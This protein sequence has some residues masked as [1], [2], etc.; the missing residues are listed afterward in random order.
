M[1]TYVELLQRLDFV[2]S[3]LRSFSE[4][5]L[6]V[7][8]D[9]AAKGLVLLTVAG[10]LVLAMKKASAAARQTVWLLALAALIALPI[11]SAALPSW[12]ILPGWVKI[13]IAEPAE[14]A[15]AGGTDSAA[16]L[17][18]ATP[19][20][21]LRGAEQA[22]AHAIVP[23]GD[24]TSS[25]PR[26]A[27]EPAQQAGRDTISPAVTTVKPSGP[28][29]TWRSW[30]IPS[31][32]AA[33]LAG[34]FVCLLPVILGRISLHRLARRS[35]R[36]D[37][38]LAASKR[39]GTAERSADGSPDVWAELLRRAAQ[40]VGL[41]RPITLLQSSD[42]TMPMVWGILRPKLL[43]PAEA[44]DWTLQR[45]WVVLL[46]ELAHAHRRDC[47]AKL[48]AHVACSLYWFNPLCWVAFKLMQREAEAACDDLV[49]MECGG[50]ALSLAKGGAAAFPA[51][52]RSQGG[53]DATALQ[54]IR[55]SDYA[56]HLLEIA[57]GLP[58]RSCAKPGPDNDSSVTSRPSGM[59]AA[60]LP[61]AC[62]GASSIA[63]ARRSKLEGRLLAILDPRRN[64]RALTR[65]GIIIAAAIVI[66]IAVPLACIKAAAPQRF[67]DATIELYV[68]LESGK[69]VPSS[70]P[71][72]VLKVTDKKQ[73][74]ELLAFFPE[75]DSKPWNQR[76]AGWI[77]GAVIELNKPDGNKVTIHVSE[78]DDLQVYSSSSGEGDKQVK[79][80]LRAFLLALQKQQSTQLPAAAHDKFVGV[81]IHQRQ[82]NPGEGEPTVYVMVLRADGKW[83]NVWVWGDPQH[84]NRVTIK[85]AGP[86]WRIHSLRAEMSVSRGLTP[87]GKFALEL[88]YDENNYIDVGEC[89]L[90]DA[91]TLVSYS[92]SS[93]LTRQD[94]N[95]ASPELARQLEIA[96]DTPVATQP[97]GQVNWG[98][99]VDG[100]KVS[101]SL[102]GKVFDAGKPI[103]IRWAIRNV[104]NEDKTIRWHELHYCPVLF[105]VTDA[106]GKVFPDRQDIR[107]FSNG[108]LPAP[109]QK[110][111]LRP[112]ETK[113]TTFDLSRFLGQLS[114]ELKI[115]GL[116][117]PQAAQKYVNDPIIPDVAMVRVASEPV[118]LTVYRSIAGGR[119]ELDKGIPFKAQVWH[120]PDPPH[121]KDPWMVAGAESLRFEQRDGLLVGRLK[122]GYASWPKDTYLAR[123]DLHDKDGKV[124]A[125]D[126]TSIQSSG[127]ILGTAKW[128]EETLQFDFGPLAQLGQISSFRISLSRVNEN[129]QSQPATQPREESDEK[130]LKDAAEKLADATGRQWMLQDKPQE[131][132]LTLS[133]EF[134]RS[135]PRRVFTAYMIYPMPW[136]VEA[137]ERWN[138]A[139]AATHYLPIAT[140]DQ[141]TLLLTGEEDKEVSDKIIRVLGIKRLKDA[142]EVLPALEPAS[143]PVTQPANKPA[144][145]IYLITGQPKDVLF[146]KV[147]LDD[148]TLAD[149]PLISQGDILEYDWESHTIRL[150]SQALADR[151][152]KRKGVGDTDT[153]VVVADGQRLYAGV[154]MS[155]ISSYLPHTPVIHVGYE[156]EEHQPAKAVR[157]FPSPWS[158]A[159][160]PRYDERLKEALQALHLLS[161]PDPASQ[162]TTQGQDEQL[163]QALVGQWLEQHN[164]RKLTF[165]PD[166]TWEET[167]WDL[168][169]NVSDPEWHKQLLWRGTWELDGRTLKRKV[170]QCPDNPA[171][172][173]EEI[174]HEIRSIKASSLE[175]RLPAL[176]GYG[177]LDDY[178]RITSMAD[179]APVTE[180]V[181]V[182]LEIDKAVVA[183][184]HVKAR[185]LVQTL[186]SLPAGVVATPPATQHM[187][188]KLDLRTVPNAVGSSRQ[189]ATQPV[190][191]EVAT[192]QAA[193]AALVLHIVSKAEWQKAAGVGVYR[194]E[195]LKSAG[196]VHCSTPQQIIRVANDNFRGTGGLVLLCIDP[197]RLKT[198]LKYENLDGGTS[199]FPHIYGPLNLDAVVEV[200]D[201]APQADGTFLL[202]GVV[203]DLGERSRAA[204]SAAAISATRAASSK[205]SAA[206]R[207]PVGQIQ[208]R[209][210]S[211][212]DHG[213]L[214]EVKNQTYLDI[215]SGDY[216]PGQAREWPH[217]HE[218]LV[219]Q[220]V[221]LK[222]GVQGK[223]KVVAVNMKLVEASFPDGLAIGRHDLT[224]QAFSLENAV[225]FLSRDTQKQ[226]QELQ[227]ETTYFFRTQEGSIG[228]IR[229]GDF[230]GTEPPAKSVEYRI[231]QE[232]PW[233]E[234]ASGLQV[235]AR[236]EQSDWP[237]GKPPVVF[238]DLRNMGKDSIDYLGIA[239]AECQLRIDGTW[240][241]WSQPLAISTPVQRLDSSE[242]VVG[243]VQVELTDRWAKPSKGERPKWAPG[244]SE[245]WGEHLHLA[246]GQYTLQV[247]FAPRPSKLEAISNPVH[248]EMTKAHASQTLPT[249]TR[250]AAAPT[251][252]PATQPAGSKLEF[253]IVP[254]ASD[255]PERDLYLGWLKA[256]RIGFW[257]KAGSSPSEQ[258]AGT[259]PMCAWLPI[260]GE[261]TNSPQLIAGEY[262]GQ[263]YVLVSDKPEQ[264]MAGPQP[265]DP[266]ATTKA[267]P[268]QE[269]DAWGLAKA[270]VTKDQFNQPAVGFELDERGAELF[271][272]LTKA[273]INNALAIVIDGKVVSVP[274]IRAVSGKQ[275][276]ITGKFTEQE[277]IALVQALRAGMPPV[278]PASSG[279]ATQ[280]ATTAPSA[281]LDEKIR[282]LHQAAAGGHGDAVLDLVGQGTPIDAADENGKTAL[283][284]AA[285]G[286][287]GQTV[288]R[289]VELGANVNA[290]DKSKQTPLLLA[291]AAGHRDVAQRLLDL[292]ADI[293]LVDDSNS[294]PIDVA[295]Q[296]GHQELAEFL[297]TASQRAVLGDFKSLKITAT[298]TIF[299]TPPTIEIKADGTCICQVSVRI[300]GEMIQRRHEFR[301]SQALIQELQ[302]GLEKSKSLT[303]K[304]DPV[305][306][307][308]VPAWTFSLSGG[309]QPAKATA[310]D[311]RD[312]PYKELIHLARSIA[313]QERLMV[314][315]EYGRKDRLQAWGE[316]RGH[317][318]ALRGMPGTTR[319]YLLID[320]SRYLP[321]SQL[322]FKN[323][324]QGQDEELR[325]AMALAVHFNQTSQIEQIAKLRHDR[326]GYVRDDA[327]MALA[328]L[329]GPKAIDWLI[330]M[331]DN[332]QARLELLKMGEPALPAVVP[333]IV[334]G[335]HPSDI[336]SVK[337]VRTYLD[338]WEQL[339]P[340]SEQF[341]NAVR[342]G[343]K[344]STDFKEYYQQFLSKAA[345]SA[346]IPDHQ[347]QS[348]PAS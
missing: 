91:N 96:I 256:G 180:R 233:G 301:L 323:P 347:I 186:N 109:P 38:S 228:V 75:M 332:D 320:Y 209:V 248:F 236:L 45:R 152:L 67:T 78:N 49:L 122:F 220:G 7:L 240:Y 326:D 12:A 191:A 79:G 324:V 159:P 337:I 269:K 261:L 304:S 23:P 149:E 77:A 333:L 339:P 329:A 230:I 168:Q 161:R 259:I 322:I 328:A 174:V 136:T 5:W 306:P 303:A 21:P 59:L 212:T 26:V 69:Y 192:T 229:L 31:A 140:G 8:L 200:L 6:P 88:H 133:A 272:T 211:L 37:I 266:G 267:L 61:R 305:P 144:V 155:D 129:P 315:L 283:H 39:P 348:R 1:N 80:N 297:Q 114:G 234:A 325:A 141:C 158:G 247:L 178:D 16:A 175:L 139:L 54:E 48:I 116:Y 279:Q 166:G 86:Q 311:W 52:H 215:D 185:Q 176:G 2:A 341:I 14:P 282:K 92:F 27:I 41:R 276:T 153:F 273:N 278:P 204:K 242:K 290:R 22:D 131:R 156:F 125:T 64:H 316:I 231:L 284:L 148:F 142:Q 110:L 121:R 66:A 195:S 53:V 62:R 40:A 25:G 35:R 99:A 213:N 222:L 90:Q 181:K 85:Q 9:A 11:A 296:H 60:R 292:G 235:R 331:I 249:A 157:L 34:A 221:D 163:K 334:K 171:R 338:K 298:Q 117:N 63:M 115:V 243:A 312:G 227:A 55:P 128:H 126:Q 135:Q 123:L 179:G 36:I 189:P 239:P 262:D 207:Q 164:P 219:R 194:P 120:E 218:D 165:H 73:L 4:A 50:R 226:E 68:D 98:Q 146:E 345:V 162:P 46:H 327:A 24:Y 43:M 340:P 89:A 44:E 15:A 18:L 184:D 145:G 208:Q 137:R 83:A 260:S 264:V 245:A 160:D 172:V 19:P 103:P 319:P 32:V 97:A 275:G 202:P 246:S 119:F 203:A 199:L 198:P 183:G 13:E 106:D 244:V 33:W 224:H 17:A 29:D 112:S 293:N 58:R 317:F 295:S 318:E 30:V 151:I 143:E 111:I 147:P 252:A 309:D 201:F 206:A 343:L 237:T 154:M 190:G 130:F 280:P 232:A 344:N 132:G 257:W 346:E 93:V 251:S 330:E 307:P 289:L 210:L 193:E 167:M 217:L 274:I 113:E 173:G 70:Q 253:R 74:D 134:T 263:K 101:I 124:I 255:V 299:E 102:D 225:S 335:T 94:W 47:L 169:A 310:W 287:H 71:V 270:Y 258:P 3:G 271:S 177:P 188:S 28:A 127:T 196:F 82:D 241:G 336:V 238:L 321:L 285:M 56:Q 150:K 223:V 20:A 288:E 118:S 87:P 138:S 65:L 108:A 314:K 170:R 107:R 100:L 104:S 277:A 95:K 42:E 187:G 265:P 81:W 254:K 291:A 250:P 281:A 313:H 268:G 182:S 197:H 342:Q 216:L 84:P 105:D 72:A 57:T 286:G 51:E 302:A 308:D 294:K 76:S 205:S 214:Q 300:E 10:L